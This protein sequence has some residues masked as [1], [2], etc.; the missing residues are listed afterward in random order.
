[1]NKTFVYTLTNMH[2]GRKI[3]EKIVASDL[4]EADAKLE[5]YLGDCLDFYS[6]SIPEE[7]PAT[8]N[9]QDEEIVLSEPC[10]VR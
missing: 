4:H 1:M 7:H 10:L 3:Q 2:N 5:S 8:V 6:A 9:S